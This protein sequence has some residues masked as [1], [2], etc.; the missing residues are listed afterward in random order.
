M[1]LLSVLSTMFWLGDSFYCVS[2]A[3]NRAFT[4]VV[5]RTEHTW[6]QECFT[7]K[8]GSM[9]SLEG[10][11]RRFCRKTLDIDTTLQRSTAGVNEG[12]SFQTHAHACTQYLSG[13][14]VHCDVNDAIIVTALL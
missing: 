1:H 2:F 3:L 11:S 5:D 9:E 7:I 12:L 4:N 14:L 13:V 10:F 6:V 8:P